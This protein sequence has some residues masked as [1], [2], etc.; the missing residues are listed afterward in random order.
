MLIHYIDQSSQLTLHS[1]VPTQQL[2]PASLP[3]SQYMT[4]VNCPSIWRSHLQSITFSDL[5]NKGISDLKRSY[6]N[7]QQHIHERHLWYYG[8][9]CALCENLFCYH[10]GKM[11]LLEAAAG[12][13]TAV[14]IDLGNSFM[15]LREHIQGAHGGC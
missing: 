15:T 14:K 9:G 12:N 3:N 2:Q 7:L 6:Q 8:A 4:C 13:F 1:P 11:L 10:L 5:E